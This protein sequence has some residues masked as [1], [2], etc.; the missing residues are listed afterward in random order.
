MPGAHMPRA[1][2]TG[3]Y[4]SGAHMPRAHMPGG[5]HAAGGVQ[6]IPDLSCQMHFVNFHVRL[7]K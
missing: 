6:C 4:I 3:A 2:M 5:A 7:L 1:D